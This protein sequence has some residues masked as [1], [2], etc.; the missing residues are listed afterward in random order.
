MSE[1]IVH[2]T[3][4]LTRAGN[5]VD[6]HW[7]NVHPG[8]GAAPHSGLRQY[9]ARRPTATRAALA[10]IYARTRPPTPESP[11]EPR[12]GRVRLAP[13]RFAIQ[14]APARARGNSDRSHWSRPTRCRL[15]RALAVRWAP[16]SQPHA[17]GRFGDLEQSQSSGRVWPGS[18]RSAHRVGSERD[19]A[20]AHEPRGIGD[21]FPGAGMAGLSDAIGPQADE[22]PVH[23][24]ERVSGLLDEVGVRLGC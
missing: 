6:G 1:P 9:V 11:V 20:E 19:P 13:K 15:A 24:R 3:A 21:A 2:R 5:G 14:P 8:S 22:H 17:C 7:S 4:S 18:S 10:R 16:H 12:R 23:L